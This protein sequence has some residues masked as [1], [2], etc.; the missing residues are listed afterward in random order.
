MKSA[1]VPAGIGTLLARVLAKLGAKKKPG[2][3]CAVREQKL[4][5][6]GWSMRSKFLNLWKRISPP[7]TK[8]QRRENLIEQHLRPAAN[9]EKDVLRRMSKDER[10]AALLAAQQAM[11]LNGRQ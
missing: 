1:T 3:G 6:C 5:R 9:T 10:R 8:T 4:N 2:C 7:P 11:T